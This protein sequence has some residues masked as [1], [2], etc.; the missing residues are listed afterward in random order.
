MTHLLDT[1]AVL[2]HFMG[3]PGGDRVGEWLGRGP[4]KTAIAAP[5]VVELASRLAELV[6]NEREER[7]ILGLYTRE[8][9]TLVPVDEESAIAAIALRRASPERLPLVDALIAGCAGA[10]GLVLVHRDRHLAAIPQSALRS[11]Y[12]E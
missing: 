11:V 10:R 1:S 7:R 12:L 4:D 6:R 9:T 2:L 3:E 8:L 5:S